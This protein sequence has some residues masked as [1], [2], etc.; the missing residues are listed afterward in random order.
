MNAR[1]LKLLGLPIALLV[2]GCSTEPNEARTGSARVAALTSGDVD[3]VDILVDGV[4]EATLGAGETSV[5]IGDIPVGTYTFSAN[6]YDEG[7][8]PDAS[9]DVLIYQGSAPG[10]TVTEGGTVSVTII[11]QQLVDV[12]DPFNND[13]P[14]FQSFVFSPASPV[15]NE[16]V[17]LTVTADDGDGDPLTFAWTAPGGV[18]DA[19]PPPIDPN[20]TASVEWTTPA[21]SGDYEIT[22]TASDGSAT[23]ELT[24]TITVD[25]ERGDANVTLEFNNFP[26]VS[27]LVPV[28][29]RIDVAPGDNTTSLS[30]TATDPDGDDLTYAWS[31]SGCVGT[32][33]DA[34]A[35]P[36]F[37]LTD[38]LGNDTCTLSVD[39]TDNRDG[40]N[41]AEVTL[42]TGPEIAPSGVTELTCA[43]SGGGST[44]VNYFVEPGPE[45]IP[46][47]GAVE[48]DCE[49]INGEWSCRAAF[50]AVMGPYPLVDLGELCVLPMPSDYCDRGAISC[51]AGQD[52]NVTLEQRHNIGTCV[53]NPGCRANC[54]SYCAGK[55]AVRV[56]NSPACEGFCRQSDIGICLPEFYTGTPDPAL[57]ACGVGD[58]CDES[59]FTDLT[60]T[61][62]EGFCGCQCLTV[63]DGNAAGPGEALL[64]IGYAYNLLL[65]PDDYGDDEQPCTSDDQPTVTVPPTCLPYT[66]STATIN[67]PDAAYEPPVG[68]GNIPI[69]G[70]INPPPATGVPFQC[71]DGAPSVVSG[72]RLQGVVASKDTSR[73]DEATEVT[74]T[75]E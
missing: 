25:L 74:I 23:A 27:D 59:V 46:I 66:T 61:G 35:N 5:T 43:F 7:T 31:A 63:G 22:V 53:D 29:T 52:R 28:P 70:A 30:L 68:G 64:N 54:E 36:V 58:T 11:L 45:I 51:D 9:D 49:A 19:S 40:A 34:T 16:T 21:L 75:C 10:V 48:M 44:I 32:F 37:T 41:T 39:I 12:P 42:A 26:L 14:I 13:V 62:H 73:W 3:R 38:R 50:A 4:V 33:S 56:A 24:I 2:V 47:D 55:G 18:V 8:L 20:T 65:G 6:A 17:I 71:V 67:L 15:V 1:A 60:S 57:V 69:N 72:V